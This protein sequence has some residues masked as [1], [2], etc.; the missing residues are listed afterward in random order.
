MKQ[1]TEAEIRIKLATDE[2]WVRRALIRL[3]ERQTASE[4]VQ[5]TTRNR[6]GRGFTPA[7][8]KWLTRMAEFVKKNPSK[9]LSVK[10]LAM[11]GIAAPG[12]IG[13][14]KLYKGEPCII[15][16]AGQ[17]LKVIEEDHAV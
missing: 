12:Y 6:N 5:E 16:Y 9:P 11:C 13:Y 15:K 3:L 4:Q 1:Y 8:A 14:V 7:D 2:Q 10:Q 17:L